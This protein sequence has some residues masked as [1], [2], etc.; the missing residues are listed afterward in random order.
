MIKSNPIP[1]R[2]VTHRLENNYTKEVLPLLWWF[3]APCQASQPGLQ[4]RDRESLGNLTLK[5]SEIWL[6][7]FHRSG[8]NR[9]HSWRAHQEMARVNDNILRISELKMDW[10]GW[11]LLRWPLYLLLWQEFLRRN[12]VALIV[13][14]RVWNTVLGCNL[15]NYRMISVHFQGKPFNIMVIQVYTPTGNAEEAEVEWF[16]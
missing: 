14:K 9:F 4:Q 1:A 16:Y 10:N 12:R 11:I 2:R 6:Q 5:A 7:D 8:R 15:K 13:N 3:W